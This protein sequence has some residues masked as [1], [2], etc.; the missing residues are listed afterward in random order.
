MNSKST[1]LPR[2]DER[3]IFSPVNPLGPTTGKVKSG[4]PEVGVVSVVVVEGGGG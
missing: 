3:E 1:T 4:A 2:N